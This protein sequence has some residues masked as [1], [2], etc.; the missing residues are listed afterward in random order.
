MNPEQ[1]RGARHRKRRIVP[2]DA[3]PKAGPQSV[4]HIFEAVECSQRHRFHRRTAGNHGNGI[5][6]KGTALR[7]QRLVIFGAENAHHLLSAANGAD[8]KAPADDLSGGNQVRLEIIA[9]GSAGISLPQIE[10]LIG[11]DQDAVFAGRC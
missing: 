7:Q 2:N 11:Q 4:T 1:G 5:C 6:G 10:D 8:R 9:R 3:C